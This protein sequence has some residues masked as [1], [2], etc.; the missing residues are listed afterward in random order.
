MRTENPYPGH[1]YAHDGDGLDG[2]DNITGTGATEQE[3]IDDLA[4]KLEEE[5]WDSSR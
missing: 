1:W 3:A 4:F 2:P 5:T